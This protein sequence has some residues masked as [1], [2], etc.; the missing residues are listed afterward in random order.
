MRRALV[1]G[2]ILSIAI[3]LLAL[4][5]SALAYDNEWTALG[6]PPMVGD[7]LRLSP[8]FASDRTMF[9]AS[10]GEYSTSATLANGGIVRSTD[11]GK[12]WTK[13]GYSQGAK[14][15]TALAL[16]PNYTLASGVVLA[17]TG[18]AAGRL[19]RSTDGGATWS[20]VG[21]S[22]PSVGPVADIRFSPAFASDRTAFVSYS[23]GARVAFSR[24][25]GATWQTPNSRFDGT[26][27]DVAASGA[28]AIALGTEFSNSG[29]EASVS[30]LRTGDGG[31]WNVTKRSGAPFVAV[32]MTG[33][34][35]AVATTADGATFS[36]NDG[37]ATWSPRG[38]MPRRGDTDESMGVTGLEMFDSNVGYAC[39]AL[40]VYRTTD[41]AAS[42]TNVSPT[43]P[44]DDEGFP[45]GWLPAFSAV[46]AVSATEAWV[47]VASDYDNPVLYHTYNG[48]SSW[49][50]T[51]LPAGGLT[52]FDL[53]AVAFGDANHGCA[54]GMA[55]DG[56]LRA[57]AY[58]TS[59]GGSSWSRTYSVPGHRIEDVAFSTPT[60]CVAVGSVYRGE[61]SVYVVLRSTD[62]G[63]HWTEIANPSSSVESVAFGDSARGLIAGSRL[64]ASSDAG[65]TWTETNAGPPTGHLAISSGFASDNLVLLGTAENDEVTYAALPPLYTSRDGGYNWGPVATTGL[66]GKILAIECSPTFPTDHI[67]LALNDAH[68]LFRSTNGGA[69]WKKVL[70]PIYTLT[71]GER[72]PRFS[73]NWASD[74]TVFVVMQGLMFKSVNSGASFYPLGS[75][76]TE[77]T[78]A[79]DIRPDFS[80]NPVA[81]GLAPQTTLW[82]TRSLFTYRFGARHK[83]RLSKPVVGSAVNGYGRL[84]YMRGT[85]S[86]VHPH[87]DTSQMWWGGPAMKLYLER[88]SGSRYRPYKSYVK[89]TYWYG[90]DYELVVYWKDLPRGNYR[91]RAYHTCSGDGG[92]TASWSSWTYFTRASSFSYWTRK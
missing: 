16:A 36:S 66:S 86:P 43:L 3:L 85:L 6:K 29:G 81:Y 79:F 35:T 50:R 44:T 75:H 1:G 56:N 22:L 61:N 77:L 63:A 59:N 62:G 11:G 37:G 34:S 47:T 20:R 13:V 92:H 76:A 33:P 30:I 58:T 46:E 69:S 12:A 57:V 9:L 70:G 14:S 83:A 25:G 60:G 40:G 68:T 53:E 90:A 19:F 67:A 87:V 42:W 4:P 49:T 82:K 8:K 21:A 26:L 10:E 55:Y 73:P 41:G 39:G 24:D 17:G 72:G 71:E 84:I 45:I 28:A 32:D 18:D 80:R 52:Q 5:A 23:G 88:Q 48:G 65:A 31:R 91:I 54:V 15:V 27:F 64:L 7:I 51:T 74:H 38:V 2:T 89:P 78:G